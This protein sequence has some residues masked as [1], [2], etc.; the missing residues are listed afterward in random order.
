MKKSVNIA[1]IQLYVETKEDW[2]RYDSYQK[3]YI[4]L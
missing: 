4:Q 1:E 2:T 3:A